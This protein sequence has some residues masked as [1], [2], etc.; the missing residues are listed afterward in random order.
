MPTYEYECSGCGHAFEAWQSMIDRKLRKCP[1]CAALKL[2]R[3]IGAG[4]GVIFKGSG[5]YETDYKRKTAGKTPVSPAGGPAD[6][7]SGKSAPALP[8]G[9]P[10]LPAAKPSDHGCQASS[11]TCGCGS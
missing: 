10:A 3:L 2:D 7:S 9:G 1:Q 11:G 4:G 8:A 5:F 6:A